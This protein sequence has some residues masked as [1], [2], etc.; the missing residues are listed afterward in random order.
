[1]NKSASDPKET[2][3]ILRILRNYLRVVACLSAILIGA[4]QRSVV[5]NVF[6]LPDN[7]SGPLLLI[8]VPG[9]GQ[10][11]ET[12]DGRYV[13]EFSDKGVLCV[14][15]FD[16]FMP[17]FRLHVQYKDGSPIPQAD[18][19]NFSD[20]RA[21]S[22]GQKWSATTST[23]VDGPKTDLSD[24]EFLFAVGNSDQIH[25]IQEAWLDETPRFKRDYCKGTA[26]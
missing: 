17:R 13:Y 18:N 7:Y 10:V 15:S 1:V 4:C 24:P 14:R 22:L 19:T 26:Q 9:S 5:E 6:I 12:K 21:A 20:N 25:S 16:S 8:S 23:G 2:L 11:H 3:A